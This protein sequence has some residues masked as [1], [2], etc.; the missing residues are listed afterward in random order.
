MI[1]PH[2]ILAA[3][4][5]LSVSRWELLAATWFGQKIVS[6]DSGCIVTMY[7]WRGKFYVTDMK[8]TDQS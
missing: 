2:N 7:R 4:T 5:T 3:W 8:Y 6:E 1:T